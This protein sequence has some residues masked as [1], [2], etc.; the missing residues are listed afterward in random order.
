MSQRPSR[1]SDRLTNDNS[2][3]AGVWL[4]ILT[5]C[6]LLVPAAKF[7]QIERAKRILCDEESRK[8]YDKWLDSGLCISYSE[9]CARKDLAQHVCYFNLLMQTVYSY[10]S[11]IFCAFSIDYSRCIGQLLQNL[12][13][14]F[15][16][17]AM[18]SKRRVCRAIPLHNG[19]FFLVNTFI[20]YIFRLR[21]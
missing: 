6:L 5:S 8:N 17:P 7:A 11:T 4:Y 16:K 20:T 1:R 12:K 15:R 14:C 19:K 2:F 13:E 9:W 21:K 3:F 18:T 10:C